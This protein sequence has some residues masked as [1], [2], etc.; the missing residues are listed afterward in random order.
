[1]PVSMQT[2]PPQLN[3][4]AARLSFR[5][6]VAGVE[7]YDVLRRKW[8]LLT[9]EEWVR[10]HFV[11]Y[12][13]DTLGFPASL[14]GNEI[15]IRLN[16]TLRRCDTVVYS[17]SLEPLMIVEYKAP[18]VAIDQKVIDQ[19]MR[20]NVVLRVP[21]LVVSNGMHHYCIMFDAATGKYKLLTRIPRYEEL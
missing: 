6:G 17:S 21:Y 10:Q 4:P 18:S 11:H 12:L 7:V 9:S 2:P 14:M 1:M 8:L 16:S 13:I 20:Y 3:L 5:T 15:G 19:I